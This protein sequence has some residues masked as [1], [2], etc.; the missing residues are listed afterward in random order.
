MVYLTVHGISKW[1]AERVKKGTMPV[2]QMNF[3]NWGW[4]DEAGPEDRAATEEF[5]GNL[6]GRF[7]VQQIK[8]LTRPKLDD[9][10]IPGSLLSAPPGLAHLCSRDPDERLIHSLGKSFADLARAALRDVPRFTDMVAYPET[11]EDVKDLIDWA[12]HQNAAVIPFGGGSSVCGGVDPDVGG[13]YEAVLTI[14]L[15]HLNKVLEVDK[16]SRAARIQGGILGPDLESQLKASDYTLRHFPQSF[17]FSTLGGWIATR[18]G[19]HYATLYTHIDD[20]VESM[21][22]VSPAGITES[23]RLPGSGAGPSPDRM[24]IGSEGI[25]GIITEAWMRVQDRPKFRASV[26]VFFDDYYRA[27]DAVRALTQSWLFPANCRLIDAQEAAGATGGGKKA[28]LIVGFESAD[29]PV[30]AW[31]DRALELVADLGGEFDRTVLQ[32]KASNKEGAAGQWRNAFMQ[33]PYNRAQAIACGL[34]ADTFETSIT[35]DRFADFHAEITAHMKNVFR[36]VTGH[37]GQITCRFTHAY[38]DG[39]APYFTWSTLGDVNKMI[40]QWRVIKAES[41]SIVAKLDGTVT[42]HHAVGRDHRPGYEQQTEPL[43]R[44]ALQA[45]KNQFDPSGVMNPGVLIDPQDRKVGQT[46]VMNFDS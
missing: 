43:F 34:V 4:A 24:M 38:P 1:K 5:A 44:S 21:R 22:V 9:F 2:R 7:G 30:D 25:L 12:G 37:E 16:T 36:E 39:V 6:A 17:E 23:R 35:W 14:D 32:K 41:M 45:A 15:R 20:M 40:D 13:G 19:G 10:E 28:M 33:A 8:P 3:W 27:A 46:G 11:E 31:I 29:H 18:S 26:P 42:H